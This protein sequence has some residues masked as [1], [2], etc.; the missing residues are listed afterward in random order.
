MARR[1][2]NEMSTAVT[3]PR[4]RS[5][6]EPQTQPKFQWLTIQEL[7]DQGGGCN[8]GIVKV[9]FK[10]DLYPKRCFIEKRF[11]RDIVVRNMARKEI[12][13]L[14]QLGDWPGVVKM[15]DHYLDES[16]KKASV[17]LEYCDG[18]DLQALISRCR[19]ENQRVHERK[20]WDW[21]M[22]LM[23]ALVY[24]HRGPNP[25]NDRDVHLY[26]NVVYHCDIKPGNIFLK[27]KESEGKIVA[28]LADF[29]CSQSAHWA[30][31]AKPT[32]KIGLASALTPGYDPPEHPQ[33]SGATDVWQL[34]LCIASVCTGTV[35]PR[36]RQNPE[37]QRWSRRQPAGAHYS[38]ELNEVLS[39]CLI[40]DKQRRPRPIE[41]SKR[42]K[43]KYQSVKLPSD[44]NPMVI[45]G[46]SKGPRAEYQHPASS[47]GPGCV[48]QQANL[49]QRSGL[50]PHAFSDPEIERIEHRDNQY[51]AFEQNYAP[52]VPA[53]SINEMMH[54][55]GGYPHP[56]FPRGPGFWHGHRG[57]PPGFGRGAYDPRRHPWG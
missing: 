55:G 17:W 5:S 13:L 11:S 27:T 14:R 26:W 56:G 15:V 52:A 54:G 39:W 34:A 41:I 10:G 6:F 57:F 38:R 45:F 22:I 47:P 19:R 3:T 1:G 42:L 48:G 44:D 31:V 28:K 36:S 50:H 53:L 9:R 40:D 37:G 16:R 49:D 2:T 35:D 32:N 8:G 7:G 20:I 43:E 30:Q 4:L 25:E 24:L 21:L 46:S 51:D 23:D 33:Y 18:G 29:G 12:Y